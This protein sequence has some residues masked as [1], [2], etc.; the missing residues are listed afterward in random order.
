MFEC[1][2][3]S[4]TLR[5]FKRLIIR[6]EIREGGLESSV[7]LEEIPILT[8]TSPICELNT[9][10]PSNLNFDAWT[11]ITFDETTMIDLSCLSNIAS[12]VVVYIAGF[13]AFSLNKKTD[14]F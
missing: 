4:P 7:P 2:N 11:D 8:N 10:T 12:H 1:H 6:A 3:N 9:S 14:V 5:Q 13:V